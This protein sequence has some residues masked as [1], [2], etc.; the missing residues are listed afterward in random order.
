MAELNAGKDTVEDLMDKYDDTP[1]SD[2]AID[3]ELAAMKARLGLDD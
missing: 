1:S 2:S 3:D